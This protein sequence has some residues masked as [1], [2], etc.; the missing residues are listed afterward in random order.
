M[1]SREL[2]GYIKKNDIQVSFAGG[3]MTATPR[4]L[5][6]PAAEAFRKNKAL[7]EI[8]ARGTYT[9]WQSVTHKIRDECGEPGKCYRCLDWYPVYLRGGEHSGLCQSREDIRLKLQNQ[10]ERIL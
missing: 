9:D 1:K 10:E 6:E 7:L 8:R 3:K 5:V 2:L 4:E